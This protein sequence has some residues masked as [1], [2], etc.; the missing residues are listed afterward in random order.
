MVVVHDWYYLLHCGRGAARPDTQ[1]RH[2]TH[3]S[4]GQSCDACGQ[5]VPHCRG[6]RLHTAL[7]ETCSI[8]HLQVP[9]MQA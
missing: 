1:G 3:T 5:V 9:M 8:I 7:Q 6:S 4:P 2:Q